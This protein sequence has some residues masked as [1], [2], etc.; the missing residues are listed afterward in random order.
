MYQI[1]YPSP[2]RSHQFEAKSDLDQSNKKYSNQEVNSKVGKSCAEDAYGWQGIKKDDLGRV[3]DDN[4][5]GHDNYQNGII[6]N[7]SDL[8]IYCTNWYDG[9]PGSGYFTDQA[10]VDSCTHNGVLN[11]SQ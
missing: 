1:E 11:S 7:G 6:P 4:F 5:P 9:Q 10:T 2:N 3:T 8:T